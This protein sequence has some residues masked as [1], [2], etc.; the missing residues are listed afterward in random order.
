[1]PKPPCDPLVDKKIMMLRQ[2]GLS[3]A[4]IAER[5]GLS[6]SKIRL[7]AAQKQPKDTARSYS[8]PRGTDCLCVACKRAFRGTTAR[9]SICSLSCVL[10]HAVHRQ[11]PEPVEAATSNAARPKRRLI[12]Y[13]GAESHRLASV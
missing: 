2:S 4:V 10:A 7:A 11:R 8:R 9:S 12:P 5:F 13:A 6:R 1:M 3:V